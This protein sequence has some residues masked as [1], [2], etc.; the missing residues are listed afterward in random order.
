MSVLVDFSPFS[1][2]S[3]ASLF[4]ASPSELSS[5]K[6]SS[7]AGAATGAPEELLLASAFSAASTASGEPG[8]GASGAGSMVAIG[9][10]PNKG[11]FALA[12]PDVAGSA[13][14]G[15]ADK[16]APTDGG[17]TLATAGARAACAPGGAEPWCM[18]SAVTDASSTAPPT[19]IRIFF[20][21]QRES[22]L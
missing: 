20:F 7:A 6:P 9:V 21:G 2:L 5:E 4:S 1:L 12:T 3:L 22:E 14:V 17:A 13:A 16:R 8:G 10:G 15:N 18:A 11:T 19:P